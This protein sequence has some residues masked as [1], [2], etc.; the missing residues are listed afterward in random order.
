M[1]GDVT[2]AEAP[3][4]IPLSY[5]RAIVAR[6]TR[7]QALVDVP[8]IRL[9]LAD[10]LD[11]VWRA[12]K[13]AMG[14]EYA[15]I[16]FWAFAWAGGLAVARY[17]QEHPDEVIR[18]RVLDVATGSGLCAIRAMQLGAASATG[19][20]IDPFAEA[21]VRVNARANGVRVGFIGRDLLGEEPPP[22]DVILAGDT[23]YEATFAE[24]MLPWLRKAAA[25]GSRVIV[26]DPGRQ[27]LPT[28]GLQQLAAYKVHT[29]TLLED[30]PVLDGCVFAVTDGP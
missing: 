4:R 7:L 17:L 11:S 23:W 14:G 20:D 24:R 30:R 8:G 28:T 25:N 26:G 13:V 10:D 16:P 21:S 18:R 15:P 9:R 1:T 27:Y 5:R 22:A 2:S 12:T 3:G 6:H 29:T 19:A